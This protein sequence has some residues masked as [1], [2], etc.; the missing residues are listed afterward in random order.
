MYDTF[1]LLWWLLLWVF[2][3][4]PIN[5]KLLGLLVFWFVQ[6]ELW[7]LSIWGGGRQLTYPPGIFLTKRSKEYLTGRHMYH[8]AIQRD[9]GVIWTDRDP[10][11]KVTYNISLFFWEPR[12]TDS[13]LSVTAF[14][15]TS[16]WLVTLTFT[17][18]R[19]RT[20]PR[21]TSIEHQDE[22]ST[23]VVRNNN[24]GVTTESTTNGW[25][26][27]PHMDIFYRK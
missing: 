13:S 5:V 11:T 16:P 2:R 23:S 4:V 19:A 10:V 27:S 26:D 21:Y 12:A 1:F 15:P 14:L 8:V 17:H 24:A 18:L 3:I 25:M 20:P 7:L 22:E 6:R 9:N